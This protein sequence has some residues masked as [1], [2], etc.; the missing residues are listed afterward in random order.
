VERDPG[1]L[2]RLA[3]DLHFAAVQQRNALHDRQPQAGAAGMLGTRGVDTEEAIKNPG[4]GFWWN[5]DAG[6][7]DF[8]ANRGSIIV[9]KIMIRRVMIR[10]IMVRTIMIRQ[11]MVR[12]IMV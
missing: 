11:I 2:S 6:I 4:Q 9:R 7:G 10:K 3:R 8:D 5:T 12:K 1:A